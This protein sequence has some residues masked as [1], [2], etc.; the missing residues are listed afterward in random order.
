MKKNPVSID[1]NTLAAQALYIMNSKKI[2]KT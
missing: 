1:K 2:F